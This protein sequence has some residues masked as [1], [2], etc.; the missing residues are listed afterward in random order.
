MSA[1][2]TT[3]W[4]V[5]HHGSRLRTERRSQV[6]VISL[7]NPPVNALDSIAYQE[8]T[9]V[10]AALSTS[11]DLSSVLLRA[12]HRCFCAGQDRR[13]APVP[14]RDSDTYLRNAAQAIVAATLCPVPVVV[15]VKSA[16]IGAGLI[17]ASCADV[18]VL[19]A[20]ATLSLPE[21]KYGVI[22]GFAHL[23][24]WIGMGTA[25]AVLTGDPINTQTF[26]NA[27]ALVVPTNAVDHEAERIAQS[28][29]DS[30]PEFIRSTKSEWAQSRQEIAR[31]YLKEI[32]RT[33]ELGSMNFSLPM[34]AD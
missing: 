24:T 2:T 29:A 27:G 7:D 32:E 28:I 21:R 13:D 1:P 10:F 30:D 25:A 5:G 11:T 26:Q 8:L 17:L 6:L 14:P 9:D 31:A 3:P 33:I 20:D 19:D 15:A 18:L 4:L 22:S 12:D 23:S 16:A 34:S